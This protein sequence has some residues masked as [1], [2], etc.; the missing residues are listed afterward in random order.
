[1]ANPLLHLNGLPPF[2][3]IRPEHVQPAIEQLIAD[4]RQTIENVLTQP[5]LTWDNFIV[6]LSESGDKLS[7]AWSPVSHLNSVQNSPE[8]RQAYQACL[9]L[10]SEYSTWVGQHKGLY[11]GYLAIKNSAEF[12]TYSTAQKKPLR[13]HYVILN[14]PALV[15][16]RK[17]SNATVK[18]LPVCPN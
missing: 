18:L 3:Q 14:F 12:A 15:Y 10:L 5:Q 17:N 1:M 4:C 9:P 7:R 8:L 2:S 13:I 16:R 6:P 11:E